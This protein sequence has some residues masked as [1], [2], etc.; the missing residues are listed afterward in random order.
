MQCACPFVLLE[1]YHYHAGGRLGGGDVGFSSY[2]D[3]D[4]GRGGFA[5]RDRGFGGRDYQDVRAGGG[6]EEARGFGDRDR[7]ARSFGEGFRDE[8]RGGPRSPRA[9]LCQ[10]I[11]QASSLAHGRRYDSFIK[12]YISG[13]H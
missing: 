11:C 10:H 2:R 7:G 8:P 9:G 3:R 5:E 6:Y 1:D 12:L 13:C 4:S